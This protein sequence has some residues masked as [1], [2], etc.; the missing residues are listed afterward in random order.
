MSL[1]SQY[2]INLHDAEVYKAGVWGQILIALLTQSI[3]LILIALLA[4]VKPVRSGFLQLS[5]RFS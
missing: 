3:T 4:L 5:A 2:Y 1:A